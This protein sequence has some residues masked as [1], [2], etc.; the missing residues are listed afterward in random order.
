MSCLFAYCLCQLYKIKPYYCY[1]LTFNLKQ[2]EKS[3]LSIYCNLRGK[4]L[5]SQLK[6]LLFFLKGK[7]RK[8]ESVENKETESKVHTINDT[9]IPEGFFDDPIL[10]AKVS[11][12][13]MDY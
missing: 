1:Y 4:S 13:H 11:N 7:G 3:S 5:Y 8:E 9:P 12:L 10:D 6:L 2:S